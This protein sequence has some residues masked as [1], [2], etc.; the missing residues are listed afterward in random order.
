VICFAAN[1]ITHIQSATNGLSEKIRPALSS[2]ANPFLR[3]L[4]LQSFF[5]TI[6]N[7]LSFFQI[8]IDGIAFGEFAFEHLERQ[9]IENQ[10]LNRALETFGGPHSPISSPP[11]GKAEQTSDSRILCQVK[12]F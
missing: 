7:D 10:P 6:E 4:F 3:R 1:L 12:I 11:L 2:G 9:W 8:H 5:L